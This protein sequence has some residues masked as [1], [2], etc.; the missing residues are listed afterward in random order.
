M[1]GTFVYIQMN[2]GN[3]SDSIIQHYFG[4]NLDAFTMGR[5]WLYQ[6]AIRNGYKSAGLM[7]LSSNAFVGRSPEMDLPNFYLEMGTFSLIIWIYT[8]LKISKNSLYG[9]MITTFVLLEMLTSHWADITYFWM[10]YYMVLGMANETITKSWRK[11]E[12]KGAYIV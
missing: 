1:G 8:L 11:I 12:N 4:M 5:Q 7:T 3:I 2:L 10:I 9:F 6:E